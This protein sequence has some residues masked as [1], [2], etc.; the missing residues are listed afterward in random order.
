[1]QRRDSARYHPQNITR[2][3]DLFA[4]PVVDSAM[5]LD[6]RTLPAATRQALTNLITRLILEHVHGD[7]QADREEV[8]RD[9]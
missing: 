6:W 9:D 4:P 8:R 3:F 7:R 2:Q 5:P 1:M